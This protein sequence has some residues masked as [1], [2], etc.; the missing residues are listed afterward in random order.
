MKFPCSFSR[1]VGGGGKALGS[2][3]LPVDAASNPAKAQ[4]NSD[5]LLSSRVISI[6][7]W[8]LQRIAFVGRYI[9]AGAPVAGSVQVYTFEDNLGLW[10]PLA[11]SAG[12]SPTYTCGNNVAN[13]AGPIFFDAMTLIDFP[14]VSSDLGAVNPGTAQFIVIVGAGTSPPNGQYIFAMGP[15]LTQKSF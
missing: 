8:P 12:A 13:Q 11:C 10:I 4:A 15:E 6:N 2:D 9:G 1:F 3:A 5:I 14:H 7:G